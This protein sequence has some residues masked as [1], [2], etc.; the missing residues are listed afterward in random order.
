MATTLHEDP[1][2]RFA[3][4]AVSRVCSLVQE[5][6]AAKEVVSSV[7]K[8][9]LSPVTVADFAGQALVGSL[10]EH[11]FP[12]H[13]LMGEENPD[14]LR[15]ENGRL[16]LDEVTHFVS[17]YVPGTNAEKICSWIQRGTAK[18]SRRFWTLDPIDGTRGF[19]R[20]DQYAVALALIEEG[21]VRMGV[22][23]CPHLSPSGQLG[24]SETGSLLFAV[25]GRGAWRS[26][27]TP[28]WNFERLQV[29]PC[30]DAQSL[31]LLKSVEASH[32][33][34]QL[35]TEFL[36]QLK[37]QPEPIAL[38]SQVKYS[39]VAQGSAESFF[40]LPSHKKPDHRMKI[41]DVAPGAIIVEE[42]GG[43]VSDIYGK[44]LNYGIG[45][46]VGGDPGIFVSNGFLH[47]QIIETASRLWQQS[48]PAGTP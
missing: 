46:T 23:G 36:K 41:W 9:D 38:D 13:L 5:I 43:R 10:L 4:E 2:V 7:A 39:V 14:F 21:K 42:A 19:L 20:G 6:Q 15:S 22:L 3:L 33:N 40:Y 27:L 18:N 30:R 48:R 17:R 8:D 1:E 12:E 32:T 47:D 31:R 28:P 16:V 29:S 37:V 25:K 44:K 45:Q 35:T 26:P 34:M 24:K 11:F